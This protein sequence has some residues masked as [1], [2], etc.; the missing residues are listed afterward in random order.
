MIFL[1]NAQTLQ[2]FPGGWKNY[3]CA[4]R[5]IYLLKIQILIGFT[6]TVFGATEKNKAAY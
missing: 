3:S 5:A 6:P 2:E 4:Y 1:P